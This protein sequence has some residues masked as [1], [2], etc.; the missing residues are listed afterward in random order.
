[1][2]CFRCNAALGQFDDT[3]ATLLKVVSLLLVAY[4]IGYARQHRAREIAS[5]RLETELTEARLAALQFT[6]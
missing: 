1:M 5:S 6:S 2:L 4:G 3:P